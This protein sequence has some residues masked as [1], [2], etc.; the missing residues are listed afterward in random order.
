MTPPT[1]PLTITNTLSGTKEPFEP[2]ETGKVRLYV[3]GPTV[4]D[5]AHL[6]HARCYLVWDVLYRF[7]KFARFDVTYAR[8]VTDVDDKIINR[9][10]QSEESIQAFSEKYYQRFTEDMTA[11]NIL[12]PTIEPKATESIESM[13]QGIQ[14]LLNNGMAYAVEDGSVY[15][16]T[17][18]KQ[19]YG[20]LSKKPLDD[21]RSGARVEVDSQK[22]YPLDFALWKAVD[23]LETGW[24]TPWGYGRPGWHMECSAMNYAAFGDQIDIHA[25]GADLIFPHHENEIAQSEAWT[26]AAPFARYWMHNGFVNV[27]G[28][29][30]SKSLGNFATIRTLL[31]RYDANT[32]RYFLLTHHYRVPVDFHDEAVEAAE[33]RMA[34]IHRALKQACEALGL[35]ASVLQ[36]YNWPN[37]SQLDEYPA[38]KEFATAMADDLNTSQAL[39]V[40]DEAI[41]KLNKIVQKNTGNDNHLPELRQRFKQA[42]GMLVTLGFDVQLI[43]KA[44][45]FSDAVLGQMAQ[46][47]SDCHPSA[48][49]LEAQSIETKLEALLMVRTDAKRSKNW[50][51]ADD[52]RNRLTDLGFLLMDTPAGTTWEYNTN[53]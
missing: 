35:Q 25:G 7:F 39:A 30:M 34:K 9:A 10:K 22:K 17:D 1:L 52:I 19:D 23:P 28:E 24:Q 12:A 49:A 33:N 4:Y 48:D 46:L 43:F 32:I 3:C 20:K 45:A 2:I 16:A 44:T 50:A 21:L 36:E 40:V 6:G 11:L 5:D 47:M 31:E 14:A 29:K 38:M 18:K 51:L 41:S 15:F 42:G 26:G 13:I 53:D 8:N 37:S 27:R